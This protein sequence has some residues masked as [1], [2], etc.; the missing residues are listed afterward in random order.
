MA[1]EIEALVGRLVLLET[2]KRLGISYDELVVAL[3]ARREGI[4]NFVSRDGLSFRVRWIVDKFYDPDGRIE[5]ALRAGA[6]VEDAKER[7]GGYIGQELATGN[8]ALNEGIQELLDIICGLGTPTKWD[9]TNARVGVGDSSASADP[10]QTGLQGSNKTFKA[11][12]SGYPQ[13][14]AQTASWRGTFGPSDANYAW[15]EYTVVNAADDSGKNLN[16]KVESKGT[17]SSGETWT[18]TVQITPS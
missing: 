8:L 1:S 7:F 5:A 6:S 2:S 11:M 4:P 17:K 13:R 10:S 12:D 16:R 9:N 18:L 15:N 3:A 14:S